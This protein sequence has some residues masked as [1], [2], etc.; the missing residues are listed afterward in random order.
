M[1]GIPVSRWD[2]G[3]HGCRPSLHLLPFPSL[4]PSTIPTD[5][6]NTPRVRYSLSFLTSISDLLFSLQHLQFLPNTQFS[7]VVVLSAPLQQLGLPCAIRSQPS[8][9]PFFTSLAASPRSSAP[10]E[11]AALHIVSHPYSHLSAVSHRPPVAP[12]HSKCCNPSPASAKT[13]TAQTRPPPTHT[14]SIDTLAQVP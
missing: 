12:K 5:Q 6:P 7:F 3:G 13:A 1:Q 11:G 9:N 10:Q 2:G 8:R 4:A 14:P